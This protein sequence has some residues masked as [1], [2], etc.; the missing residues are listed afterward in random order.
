[1]YIECNVL[2]KYLNNASSCKWLSGQRNAF[3]PYELTTCLHWEEVSHV[4]NS[5]NNGTGIRCKNYS[6]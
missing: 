4:D 5:N 6:H 3:D 2:Q 1:M